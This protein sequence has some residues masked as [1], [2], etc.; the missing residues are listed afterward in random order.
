MAF[1]PSN[2]MNM[3]QTFCEREAYEEKQN[4]KDEFIKSLKEIADASIQQA[5]IAQANAKD[6]Q[7]EATFSKVISIISTLIALA[8]LILSLLSALGVFK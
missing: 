8:A 6:A 3:Y 4:E 2:P 1:R 7:R 5:K